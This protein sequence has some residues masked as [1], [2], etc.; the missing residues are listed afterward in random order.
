MGVKAIAVGT[1]LKSDPVVNPSP[2]PQ[3]EVM[4]NIK[5]RKKREKVN[6]K[7]AS[8]ELLIICLFIT[9]NPESIRPQ[10]QDPIDN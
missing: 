6:C 7:T 2:F 1:L 5:A 9:G 3:N 4:M 10:I 8:G